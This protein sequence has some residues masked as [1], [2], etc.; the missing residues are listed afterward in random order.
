MMTIKQLALLFCSFPLFLFAQTDGV[1]FTLCEPF[2]ESLKDRE[3]IT[4]AKLSVPEDWSK[5]EGKKIQ[6]AVTILK[7]QSEAPSDAEPVVY[8]EGGPGAGSIGGIFMWFNHPILRTSDL[9]LVDMRGTGFSEPKLCPDLGKEILKI[10]ASNQSHEEDEAQKAE[11]AMAC[12][13]DMIA[14]GIDVNAYHAQAIAYDLHALKKALDYER[15]NVYGVSYGTQMAQEYAHYFPQDVKSLILDSAIPRIDQYY[16]ANTSNYMGSLE[17]LFVACEQDPNCNQLYPNLEE[18]YYATIAALEKA[19]LTVEVPKKVL[20]NQQFTYNAEDFKIAIHQGLYDRWLIEVIPLLITEFHR[21][22]EKTLG[23]LVEAFSR[24][25]TLDYGMY[26][27]VICNDVIPRNAMAD[28][29][30]NSAQYQSLKGGLSFYKSDFVVCEQWNKDT[31]RSDSMEN[32]SLFHSDLAVPVLVISGEFDPITPSRNGVLTQR[33]FRNSFLLNAPN[34]GHAP[35]ISNIGARIVGEFIGDPT[36]APTKT[37][38][39]PDKAV[40]FVQSVELSG[41]VSQFANSLQRFDLIFFAPLIIA[42]LVF[43]LSIFGFLYALYRSK[44]MSKANQGMNGLLILTSL[45]GVLS[46]GGLV[47]AILDTVDR[48]FYILAF[49]LPAQHGYVFLVQT[50]FLGL[51]LL[52]MAYF[53]FRVRKLSNPT[54]ISTVLF[55]GLVMSVYFYYWGFL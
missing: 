25:L 39:G 55:S 32:D 54:L 37:K 49:G 40:N 16:T 22:N 15:W 52:T 44:N 6:V 18:T 13:R 46:I 12:K 23:A 21:K 9:V 48:N 14:R 19:P 28:Y 51:L 4:W 45:L 29:H 31:D 3:D 1:S 35:S 26:Y 10:L 43:I 34:F 5:P 2:H 8:L 50:A 53:I 11:A 41:G 30:Q 38:Y 20:S 47:K 42:L 7:R 17:K 36:K 33:K 24:A 27:C